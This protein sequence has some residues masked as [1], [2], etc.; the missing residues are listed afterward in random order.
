MVEMTADLADL[1]QEGAIAPTGPD[2]SEPDTASR[3]VG[4]MVL[5]DQ[6]P[7]K[8]PPNS[9]VD[10]L[11]DSLGTLRL[12]SLVLPRW[13]PWPQ[14]RMGRHGQKHRA[15]RALVAGISALLLVSVLAT[16]LNGAF[17]AW[18]ADELRA[19]LGPVATAQIES[20]YLGVR[21][22]F[23]QAKYQATG[24][25]A[26]VPWTPPAGTPAPLSPQ[27]MPLPPLTPLV[28]PALPGEGIWTTEGMPPP[29]AKQPP[30]AAKTFL[31][32][33]PERPYAI[34]TLLQLD[35][36][37]LSLHI[38]AGTSEPGGPLGHKGPG[39][40]PAEDQVGDSLYAAFNGGF[41]YP[42]GHYGLMA[43]GTVYVPP[44]PDAATIAVTS[45]GQVLLGAWGQD[46]RLSVSNANLVAWRQN[47]ALL[48]DHGRLNPLT[49]DGA[50]WGGVW[51][52]KAYTWRSAIGLT[53]HNTL[54][55]AAGDSLSA[56]TI[57]KAMQ[58]AGAV[59][60]M[61]TDINPTW[62]RAFLYSRDANGELQIA[63]L[64]PDMQGTG[65]EYLKGTERDF[66]YF[67]R[68]PPPD[69]H[70]HDPTPTGD[71]SRPAVDGA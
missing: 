10:R 9:L 29:G 36:R 59:M 3:A 48:I 64:H 54:I 53:D 43:G 27:A 57:G 51:L 17:G 23:N 6:R 52:N 46:P 11:R 33:D 41:K 70:Q 68:T 61:Q 7:A 8:A 66:F 2:T 34:V 31:R 63:K 50:A 35:L 12:R 65:H 18:L 38:V 30:L 14:G 37:Y 32:P 60:A 49:N 69:Q 56:A 5:P 26:D 1:R 24:K 16:Q 15:R 62:V 42:D 13:V 39:V 44:Q 58:A 20:W 45:K 19:L 22:S 21:D 47:A 4:V 71:G 67:T 40:I 25:P 55:Y 28:L